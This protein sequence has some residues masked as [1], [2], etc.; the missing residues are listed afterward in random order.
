MLERSFSSFCRDEW[1]NF[2]QASEGSFLGSWTVVNARRLVGHVQL[3]EFFADYGLTAPLKVGQC[4][5]MVAGRKV[6]FLDRIHLKSAQR[7][8]W[9]Q[10]FKLV[11]ERFGGKAYHYGSRWN[12]EDLSEIDNIP[13]FVRKPILDGQFYVDL[14]DFHDWTNFRAYSRAVSENIRRDYRKAARSSASVETRSG[15]A[16]FRD[17]F[18]LITLR[19]EMMRKNKEPFSYFGDYVLHA[20]K[21]ALFG[22]N[23]IITTVRINRRCY[24]AFFGIQFGSSV[25][26]I[27]GGTRKNAHGCGS[28]LFLTLIERM[29]ANHPAGKLFMGSRPK[30]DQSGGS[31]LYKR[32][33]RI[34]SV[35]GV[36]FQVEMKHSV[37]VVQS[38][39]IFLRWFKQL[40]KTAPTSRPVSET[41]YPAG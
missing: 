32:K 23:G 22:R 10:C 39:R 20:A 33:L 41:R 30:N 16:A 6:N 9:Y 11:I 26:Y 37:G 24:S 3:F 13:E 36:E 8:L 4:A 5:V 38:W 12:Y 27:S 31:A 2:V 25:Y 1:D 35:N 34:R 14:I 21:L 40:R 18:A 17:L 28:R 15:F 19:G 7:H 29:F